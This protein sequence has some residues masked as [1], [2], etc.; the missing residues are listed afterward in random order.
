MCDLLL[1]LAR[2]PADGQKPEFRPG[3]VVGSRRV[4]SPGA[5][6]STKQ[7]KT[8]NDGIAKPEARGYFLEA[9]TFCRRLKRQLA[10]FKSEFRQVT[11]ETPQYAGTG[12]I[13]KIVPP[14]AGTALRT[15][16]GSPSLVGHLFVADAWH[17]VVSRF[18]TEN[19]HV[20]DIGCG[21]GK[22]APTLVYHPYI[23]E[24]IGFDVIRRTLTGVNI[25]FRFTDRRS[26]P[27]SLSRCSLTG[28][29]SRRNSE[30]DGRGLSRGRR[31][32]STSPSPRRS[33]PI[34]SKTTPGTICKNT[35]VLAPWG[36]SSKHSCQPFAAAVFGNECRIDV[37]PDYFVNLARSAGLRLVESLCIVR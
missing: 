31:R 17:S 27:I 5:I 8:S 21:C 9:I 33:L 4:D 11:S 1:G 16:V 36:I 14:I 34:S 29:Q 6:G 10:H 19:S 37:D 22:T 7:P 35:P 18:L 30:R 32:R 15:N 23:N 12:R 13:G 24:Y 25:T 28:L 3:L 2:Q 20:L 26:I